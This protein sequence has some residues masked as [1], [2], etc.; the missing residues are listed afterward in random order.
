MEYDFGSDIRYVQDRIRIRSDHLDQ[1]SVKKIG[2]LIK[3]RKKKII[4]QLADCCGFCE[5]LHSD[6]VFRNSDPDPFTLVDRTRN[7]A[8]VWSTHEII[9][10]KKPWYLH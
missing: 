3:T 1:D 8:W 4:V 7:S 5:G 10:A 9:R 2:N 6:P